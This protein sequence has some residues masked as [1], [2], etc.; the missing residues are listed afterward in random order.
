MKVYVLGGFLGAGKT[1][2]IRALADHVG[3]EVNGNLLAIP[4]GAAAEVE[5]A[6]VSRVEKA[7]GVFLAGRTALR[8]GYD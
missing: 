6:E 3:T 7:I 2:A 8:F 5:L 4:V 1:S